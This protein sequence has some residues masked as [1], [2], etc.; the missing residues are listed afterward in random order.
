[1]GRSLLG[2]KNK[3]F[4]RVKAPAGEFR[5]QILNIGR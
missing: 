1:M 3:E 4:I 2:K 5:Y